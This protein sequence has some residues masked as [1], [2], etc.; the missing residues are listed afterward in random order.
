MSSIKF[1]QLDEKISIENI[2]FFPVLFLYS[3][4]K[5]MIQILPLFFVFLEPHP[6]HVDV[7]RL[8]VK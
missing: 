7:S 6:W 2:S 1:S 3:P 4:G 5:V 8:E